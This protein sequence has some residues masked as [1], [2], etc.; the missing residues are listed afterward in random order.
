MYTNEIKDKLEG[1]RSEMRRRLKKPFEMP[2]V[3]PN[4]AKHLDYGALEM[5]RR[6]IYSVRQD[7]PLFTSTSCGV[8]WAYKVP[9]YNGYGGVRALDKLKSRVDRGKIK[10]DE[11]RSMRE[12][13]E[14]YCSNTCYEKQRDICK[15]GNDVSKK[16]VRGLLEA[17]GKPE[18]KFEIMNGYINVYDNVGWLESIFVRQNTSHWLLDNGG[19]DHYHTRKPKGF[20]DRFRK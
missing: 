2:S 18:A 5:A 12:K 20:F 17:I 19:M 9:C 7:M 6:T 14:G 13:G 8:S 11:V 1:R 16:E 4:G 15:K 3:S 10:A